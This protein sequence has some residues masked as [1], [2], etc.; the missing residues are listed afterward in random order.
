MII[1]GL[2]GTWNDNQQDEYQTREGA[3]TNDLNEFGNSWKEKDDE[4]RT[5]YFMKSYYFAS[6][7]SYSEFI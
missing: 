5:D 7:I 2:C 4:V 3:I 6:N 1:Q